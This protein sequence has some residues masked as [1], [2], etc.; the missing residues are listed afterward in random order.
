MSETWVGPQP[1]LLVYVDT[2]IV[3]VDY[4]QKELCYNGSLQYWVCVD[5]IKVKS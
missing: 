4:R 1:A 3:S 5:T 2:L